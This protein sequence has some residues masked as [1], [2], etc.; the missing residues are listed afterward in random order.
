MLAQ[1]VASLPS[2]QCRAGPR[3]KEGWEKRLKEV[4]CHLQC[5]TAKRMTFQG[6]AS[7]TP[8]RITLQLPCAGLPDVAER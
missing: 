8:I 1:L 2:V 6:H 5:P 4:C 7:S 3:D